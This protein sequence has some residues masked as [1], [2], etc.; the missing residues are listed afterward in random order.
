MPDWRFSVVAA[1]WITKGCHL[2][3]A[4]VEIGMKPDHRGGIVFKRV[5]TTDD[6]AEI[7]QAIAV[8]NELL[9]DQAFRRKA[10]EVVERAL[11]YL[12]GESGLLRKLAEGRQLEMRMLIH[13]L[14][15]MEKDRAD[16]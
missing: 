15:R 3:I 6:M 13:A 1:D 16:A 7:R 8:A 2:H 14:N 12:R 5:F 11:V 9:R 4:G 10:R